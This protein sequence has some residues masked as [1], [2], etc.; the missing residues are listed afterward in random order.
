M[1]FLNE[2]TAIAAENGGIIINKTAEA[3]GISRAMLYKLNREGAIQRIAQ[4]QYIVANDLQDELL[5]LSVRSSN[6]IFSHETALWLHGI[7]DRT[8]FV[9]SITAPTGKMPSKSIQENCK[10]YYVKPMLFDLGKI[11]LHTPSGNAVTSYDI[12]RTI[13]DCVRSRNRIG[14]E[15]F[16]AALKV[17]AGRRDKNLNLLHVYAEKMRVASVVHKYIEVL[18]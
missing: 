8:P 14:S 11:I 6:I 13:C 18:L 3:R 7:S 9:H 15:T 2:L 16:F 12:E 1:D 10:V 4:G 17:Y 5:S